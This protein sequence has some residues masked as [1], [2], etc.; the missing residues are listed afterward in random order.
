[1]IG[2]FNNPLTLEF[3]DDLPF[4]FRQGDRIQ[5]RDHPE[6]DWIVKYDGNKRTTDDYALISRL[7][8]SK[9]GGPLISEGTVAV[10]PH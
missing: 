6:K 10:T 9:T 5:S 7:L 1:M 8:S 2:A 4:A 3:P